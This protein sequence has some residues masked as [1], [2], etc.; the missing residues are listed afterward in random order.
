MRVHGGSDSPGSCLRARARTMI[1]EMLTQRGT[2]RALLLAS[3]QGAHRHG[4][5]D[6]RSGGKPAASGKRPA[7]D[8]DAGDIAISGCAAGHLAGLTIQSNGNVLP[9]RRLPLSLGNVQRD[10]LREIWA[11]SPVLEA[12]RDRKRYKGKC[13][14]CSRW[15]VCRGCRAIAYAWSRER[16]EDFLADD[17]QC[18]MTKRSREFEWR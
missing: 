9:C 3:G 18:F 17:P 12:L 8:G 15:A 4:D 11:D 7:R 2:R 10:S 13:G 5:C 14:S 1:S 6:R 16:R